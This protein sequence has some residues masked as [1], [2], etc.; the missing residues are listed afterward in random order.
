TA[1]SFAPPLLDLTRFPNDLIAG[2]ATS[3]TAA[4]ASAFSVVNLTKLAN[5]AVQLQP[6][7]PRLD[8]LGTTKVVLI[9]MSIYLLAYTAFGLAVITFSSPAQFQGRRPGRLVLTKDSLNWRG[10]ASKGSVVDALKWLKQDAHWVVVHLSQRLLGLLGRAA[11]DSAPAKAGDSTI[12]LA[13]IASATAVD[14]RAFG[15]LLREFSFTVLEPSNA[16][17]PSVL[18][19][20]SIVHYTELCDELEQRMHQ[21]RKHFGVD[22]IRSVWGICF[23][24]TL[25]YTLSLAALLPLLPAPLNRPLL[26]DYSLLNLYVLATPG[27]LLPLLWWFIAQPLGASSNSSWAI[28]PLA[29]TT[30]VGTALA[31]GVLS[32]SVSL[33]TFGLRPDLAT[34]VLAAGFLAA[35]VCY[36]PQ[37]PFKR[38]FAPR[39]SG[40]ARMLLAIGALVGVTML[41][42]NIVTTLRWYNALVHGNRM[43]EQALA[44]EGCANGNNGC[45]LLDQAIKSYDDVTCLR[46]SDSDGFAFRGFA[47]LVKHDYQ[48]AREDFERALGQRPPDAGCQPGAA[49]T[50][51]EAQRASLFTNIGAV[52]T[53]L[54]R[55]PPISNSE[56]HY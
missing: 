35:L 5:R 12:A 7:P 10:P 8:P 11:K 40:L 21:P 32:D 13:D 24:L 52:D 44:P 48:R 46:P 37:R 49:P 54:A 42:W 30:L 6:S 14:R 33:S 45:P 20:G 22:F 34:P 3:L 41:V 43:V 36:A 29:A 39:L 56:T 31:V 47:Y 23:L 1:L 4:E 26:L 51:T 2:R 25:L 50:P 38:M 28:I 18:I 9:I 16:K 55:Q 19:P 27:L 53:L 15:H 17:R